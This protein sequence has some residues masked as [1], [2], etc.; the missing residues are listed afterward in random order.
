MASTR[1]SHTIDYKVKGLAQLNKALK[2]SKD[3]EKSFNRIGKSSRD[4]MRIAK[5]F[6]ELDR[7]TRGNGVRKLGNDLQKTAKSARSAQSEIRRV[8]NEAD[9]IGRRKRDLVYRVRV[10]GKDKLIQLSR[11]GGTLR[12]TEPHWNGLRE[13]FRGGAQALGAEIYRALRG[14]VRIAG[15]GVVDLD[16]ALANVRATGVPKE[17]Q[18]TLITASAEASAG[19]SGVSQ[20][21][22]LDATTDDVAELYQQHEDGLLSSVELAKRLKTITKDAAE[23]LQIIGSR[24]G[25]FNTD[26]QSVK[27]LMKA[28]A[29]TNADEEA[30]RA[31]Q[32]PEAATRHMRDLIMSVVETSGGALTY[33]QARSIAQQF[34]PSFSAFSDEAIKTLLTLG[35]EGGRLAI[36]AQRSLLADMFR[37]N[38][39]DEKKKRQQELGIR[40]E[41][42]KIKKGVQKQIE[43]N[44]FEFYTKLIEKA[45]KAGVDTKNA[46]DTQVFFENAGFTQTA[47]KGI[48]DFAVHI[49]EINRRLGITSRYDPETFLK[50]PTLASSLADVK[51]SLADASGNLL[52]G[53]VPAIQTGLDAVSG[54]LTRIGNG[55]AGPGDY[56]AIAAAGAGLLGA[57][58]V[59]TPLLGPLGKIAGLQALTS[60]DPA[61]RAL[62][63]AGLS[64]QTAA[65]KLNGVGV[66]WGRGGSLPGE[67]GGKSRGIIELIAALVAALSAVEGLY[68]SGAN[69][70]KEFDEEVAKRL[71]IDPASGPYDLGFLVDVWKK[72]LFGDG[73]DVDPWKAALQEQIA[74]LEEQRATVAAVGGD[75][76]ALTA[77]LNELRAALKEA[78]PSDPKT[79]EEQNNR[80]DNAKI[81][82]LIREEFKRR[83]ALDNPDSPYFQPP[84]P[85]PRPTDP[86]DLIND[87]VPPIVYDALNA[88]GESAEIASSANNQAA[89]GASSLAE[90]TARAA[91]NANAAADAL[92]RLTNIP[93]P[94]VR[95]A[96]GPPAP[97]GNTGSTMPGR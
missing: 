86:T 39:T 70:Q 28:V 16:T 11:N 96:D 73:P 59:L 22:I 47:A 37:S 27:D 13:V 23:T 43:D 91:A 29:L 25:D 78:V 67:K 90:A 56:A 41:N 44:P 18:D 54:S 76:S 60:N 61:V 80:S 68:H 84:V 93:I 38:L 33:A 79:I 45:K 49:E 42:G 48:A 40:D 77:K 31:G 32:D 53:F 57:G 87:M 65:D 12:V 75:V 8:V 85:T 50:N 9:R 63:A 20:A 97:T 4:T 81:D 94:T 2:T 82:N 55:K 3:L 83:H 5:A 64:L 95:P 52:S 21:A 62:G 58:G 88:F 74:A 19:T 36:A 7:A 6:K 89:T 66:E 14:A 34:G 72:Q 17:V 46:I 24:T 1:D 51:T 15:E 26:P 30:R 35:E 10:E 92:A 71:G 69:G